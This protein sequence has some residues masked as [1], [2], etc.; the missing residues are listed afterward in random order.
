MT[1]AQIASTAYGLAL[2]QARDDGADPYEMLAVLALESLAMLSGRNAHRQ[3]ISH[4]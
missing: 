1:S 2:L 3:R 4:R